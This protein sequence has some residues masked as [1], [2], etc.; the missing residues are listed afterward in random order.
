MDIVVTSE[1]VGVEK[2]DKKIFEHAINELGLLPTECVMV[3]DRLDTDIAGGKGV[4][5]YTV[6]IKK[7]KRAAEKSGIENLPDYE[8]SDFSELPGILEKIE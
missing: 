1:E 7:G 5:M 2:P 6:R 4:G 3:G 8:T